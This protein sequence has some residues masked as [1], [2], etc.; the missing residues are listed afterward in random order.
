MVLG[1]GVPLEG[2]TTPSSTHTK[3]TVEMQAIISRAKISDN[4]MTIKDVG[5]VLK[6]TSIVMGSSHLM[7]V[8]DLLT[9]AGT[10]CSRLLV[11]MMLCSVKRNV[12]DQNL[13]YL[14]MGLCSRRFS[15]DHVCSW[16]YRRTAIMMAADDWMPSRSDYSIQNWKGVGRDL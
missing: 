3:V 15:T 9:K 11:I 2:S 5:W 1:N 13:F 14:H 16:R 10:D 4:A 8:H 12:V 6:R 7:I